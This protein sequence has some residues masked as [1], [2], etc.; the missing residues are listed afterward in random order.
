MTIDAAAL[1]LKSG[2]AVVLRGSSTAAR[3]NAVLAGIAAAA[4]TEAGVPED[5]IVSLAGGEPDRARGAGDAE[6]PRRPDH[7]ARRRGA[8]G[9]AR[10][11]RDGAGDLRRIGQLPRLRGRAPPISS[12]RVAITVN[13]KVQRPGVCNAAETLLVHRDAAQAFLPRALAAL[14][15][16]GVELRGDDRARELA[17]EVPVAPASGADWDTEYLALTLA[18]AVV[19]SLDDAVEHIAAHG[20]GHS[21]AIVTRDDAAARRFQ[22]RGRRGL[23][24][25]ERLD[26]LHRRRRVRDGRRD[27][28]LDPEAPRARPDRA[29][30]A[31]RRQVP[32]RG[33]RARPHLTAVGILGGTFNPPHVAHLVCA[34]EARS[35][36]GLGE[37]AARA[38]RRTA[39]QADGGRARR[40]ASSRDVPARRSRATRTGWR[41]ARS[42][43][44]ARARPTRSIRCVRSMRHVRVTN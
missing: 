17:G 16:A 3:S 27:R 35:Q 18:V 38:D 29:A 24:V 30:R 4:A 37:G 44:S 10:G 22:L 20:T 1:C 19:D 39:P 41:S 40:R 26:P 32:R 34:S 12:R 6:P 33:R 36:L 9:G 15:D 14:H 42:R 8:E 2:N 23:R 7:P 25:R 28:Q 5:A 43:S 21:E 31:V 13:A 11:A